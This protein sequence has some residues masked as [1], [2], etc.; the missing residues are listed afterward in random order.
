[1]SSS[2][3]RTEAIHSIASIIM[4]RISPPKEQTKEGYAKDSREDGE[5]AKAKDGEE[6]SCSTIEFKDLIINKGL[7]VVAG[8]GSEPA[9][10][11]TNLV[12]GDSIYFLGDEEYAI[13]EVI[14]QGDA[15]NLVF[16]FTFVIRN[17]YFYFLVLTNNIFF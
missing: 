13:F 17:C 9:K 12:K 3:T 10:K 11:Y 14:T 1:M 5:E 2:G 15:I 6:K 8:S 16:Y 7:P 4:S